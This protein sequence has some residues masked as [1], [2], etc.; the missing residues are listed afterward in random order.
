[1]SD[2]NTWLNA[3]ALVAIIVGAFIGLRYRGT[4]DAI[5]GSAA[6][7]KEERDAERARADRLEREC[8][9]LSERLA[10]AEARTDQTPVLEKIER[11]VTS[12]HEL[13]ETSAGRHSAFALN[14]EGQ[15][16]LT[17]EL[18]KQMNG[19]TQLLERLAQAVIRSNGGT[20]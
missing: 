20:K 19:Q 1:M 9:S 17:Q 4:V 3:T 2:L 12:V 6:A 18:V 8:R 16:K 10:V 14:L 13:A 7:W 15:A 5:K 11:L